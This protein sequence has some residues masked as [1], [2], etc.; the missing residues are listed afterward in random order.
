MIPYG[1]PAFAAFGKLPG[2]VLAE[3]VVAG[4]E[5]LPGRRLGVVEHGVRRV[6]LASASPPQLQRRG[7]LRRL[8][9]GEFR[10]GAPEPGQELELPSSVPIAENVMPFFPAALTFAS[11]A[12]S[13]AQSLIW[14]GRRRPR[15]ARSCCS[16]APGCWRRSGRRT[17]C[18]RSARR[19]GCSASTRRCRAWS[20]R[21]CQHAGVGQ[22][23]HDR[24]VDDQDVGR[25][26]LLRREQH[27]VGQ[28]GRV[29]AGALDRHAGLGAALLSQL[30][31]VTS[32]RTAGRDP[33]RCRC[34]RS[35]PRQLCR[36]RRPRTDLPTR[37]RST[38]TRWRA[39]RSPAPQCRRPRYVAWTGVDSRSPFLDGDRPRLD[40]GNPWVFSRAG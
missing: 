8:E 36:R 34:R 26:A 38:N 35:S 7:R 28:I 33:R 6:S 5:L 23:R 12:V 22:R 3:G 24:V 13:D 21:W 15:R 30:D 31:P 27:L 20:R 18:R 4:R 9:I 29:V 32:R 40:A 25:V 2:A 17:S 10:A 14:S 37:T 19:P 1:N 16:T 39:R 11:A